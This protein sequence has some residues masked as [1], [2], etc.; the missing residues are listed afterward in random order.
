MPRQLSF[1]F[2]LAGVS[3]WSLTAASQQRARP[4]AKAAS[5]QTVVLKPA[6]VF[7]GIDA[8]PHEGWLVVVQGAKITAAGPAEGV[9]VP[10]G[11]RVI[12]LPD[13]TLIPGL[14]DAH[15]HILLHAYDEAPWDDQVL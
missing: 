13:A 8:A 10:E 5:G 11:A 2:A 6:R 14:I 3:F 4:Q 7:D 9:K 12:E 15:S 1:V